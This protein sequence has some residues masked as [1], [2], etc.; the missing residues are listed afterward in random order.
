MALEFV[1]SNFDYWYNYLLLRLHLNSLNFHQI[2]PRVC[3]LQDVIFHDC[4]F[5][6]PWNKDS[7]I[8]TTRPGPPIFLCF[9]NSA[10]PTSRHKLYQSTIVDLDL[11]VN[12]SASV[13]FIW[14]TQYQQVLR[15]HTNLNH[16]YTSHFYPY[17]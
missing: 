2:F 9:W 15:Y 12:T 17:T 13:I 6:L 8:C 1:V 5:F 14:N 16:C 3:D 11:F 7:S 4:I 10:T